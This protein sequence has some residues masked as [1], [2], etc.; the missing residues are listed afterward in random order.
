MAI[1]NLKV[2]TKEYQVDVDPSTP[3]LWYSEIILTW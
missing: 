2:N 1:F 3:M